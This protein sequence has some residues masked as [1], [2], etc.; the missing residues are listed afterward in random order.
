MVRTQVQL[1]DEQAPRLKRLA[2]RQKRSL[3]AVIR[4]AVDQYLRQHAADPEPTREELIER[5]IALGGKYRSGHSDISERHD[6]YLA[7]IYADENLHGRVR[8]LRVPGPRR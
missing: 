7:E 4:E 5:S 2:G 3:A 8:P 1:T 6:D